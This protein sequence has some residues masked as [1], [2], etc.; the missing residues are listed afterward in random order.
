MTGPIDSIRLARLA[1]PLLAFLAV[2]GAIAGPPFANPVIPSHLSGPAGMTAADLDGDGRT[3]LAITLLVTDEILIVHGADLSGAPREERY[4]VGTD[5]IAVAIGDLDR[6]GHRDLV[7]LNSSP[8]AVDDKASADISVLMARAGGGFEPE[9]RVAIPYL[10]SGR[11]LESG[12]TRGIVI[13]D[14]NGDAVPDLAVLND[15]DISILLGL[16]DGSF[17][18]G[19][20][21]AAGVRPFALVAD[22][23]DADGDIDLAA[24]NLASDDVSIAWGRGDGTFAAGPRLA[25]GITPRQLAVGDLDGNGA[26]DLV[27]ANDI[28]NDPL[29]SRVGDVSVLMGSGGGAF[30]PAVR[31]RTGDFTVNVAIGDCDEDGVPDI[32][33]GNA[34][35]GDVSVL[36]GAGDGTFESERRMRTGASQLDLTVADMDGDGHLDVAST[37]ADG[38]SI[39]K[40]FGDGTF[41]P[42]ATVDMPIEA[43]KVAVADFDGDGREDLIVVGRDGNGGTNLVALF[44]GRGDGTFRDARTPDLGAGW[45][46][47]V[48]VAVA[49]FDGD[50]QVDFAVT[51]GAYTVGVALGRG[52]WEFDPALPTEVGSLP[53]A[54]ATA[55]FN[56]DGRPDLAVA[57]RSDSGVL[58]LL[59][60]GDGTFEIGQSLP[61]GYGPVDIVAADF[62]AD[63]IVDLAVVGA[64]VEAGEYR[65]VALVW[66]GLGDGRF[67]DPRQLD[68]AREPAALAA[69][70]L[71]G[72]GLPDL[73][74]AGNFELSTL[75]NQGGGQFAPGILHAGPRTAAG[76]APA[77]F[78]RDGRLDFAVADFDREVVSIFPG[79][80]DGTLGPEMI[81]V[82]G[83]G[84]LALASGDFNGDGAADLVTADLGLDGP[85]HTRIFDLWIMLNQA[86]PPNHPPTAVVTAPAAIECSS[87]LGAVVR[88]DGTAS[89]DPDSRP[90]G[91]DDL[92][93]FDWYE[94]FGGPSETH[95]GS[96]PLLDAT[97]AVGH[98]DVTLR[99][100]DRAGATGTAGT[101]V[102]VTDSV[103][104]RLVLR[105]ASPLVLWPPD[106]KMVGIDVE[107]VADDLCGPASVV[108]ESVVS[109]ESADAPGHGGGTTEDVLGAETGT[110][111]FRFQV[112]AERAGSG[113]GRTY[114]ATYGARDAAGNATDAAITIVVPHGRPGSSSPA[115]DR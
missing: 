5:P 26:L 10:A 113:P 71:N 94:D 87:W 97:L 89:H 23:L 27:I 98:H 2:T 52:A 53:A 108:L 100:T 8:F 16:G 86:P 109:S 114:T 45:Y 18:P 29:D 66:L 15:V 103:S 92:A 46:E 34:G 95:L 102:A 25:A 6:D 63:G 43:H 90:G 115:K 59:G 106:H 22:D 67:Q 31:Y 19:G 96:G 36:L 72:D 32:V 68:V 57:H 88:L 51:D 37:I 111:D 30:A 75:L 76:I 11:P 84:P 28:L 104:P 77:D 101:E 62:D 40:G 79:A 70:D 24:T 58:I 80:G 91:P 39:V 35:S 73:M 41:G 12:I 47:A 64:I 110:P 99:V 49:D 3:D 50:G 56:G 82:A 81:F 112:R 69:G 48:A 33:A 44:P 83:R 20:R 42:Q 74:V 21:T 4:P 61:A 85:L 93:A 60:R 13:A 17:A 38:A 9:R 107:A 14:F 105:S 65:S 55:D 54:M 1:A 7:V 78:D